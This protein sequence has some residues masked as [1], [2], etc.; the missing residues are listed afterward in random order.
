MRG[1]RKYDQRNKWMQSVRLE[2]FTSLKYPR[3]R[4]WFRLPLVLPD[5]F[6]FRHHRHQLL[7]SFCQEQ[8][9]LTRSPLSSCSLSNQSDNLKVMV[10]KWKLIKKD[11]NWD[12]HFLGVV[13][14][15]VLSGMTYPEKILVSCPTPHAHSRTLKI[16]PLKQTQKSGKVKNT[17]PIIIIASR[18]ASDFSGT[19]HA[20]TLIPILTFY[21]QVLLIELMPHV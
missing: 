9:L 14:A 2:F 5:L 15:F 10:Q 3:L 6:L 8:I 7:L 18:S 4:L 1:P 12:R 19:R 21:C 11:R 13:A 16:F 17:G 20:S